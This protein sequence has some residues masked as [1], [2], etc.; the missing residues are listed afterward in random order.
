MAFFNFVVFSQVLNSS[1]LYGFIG[2]IS[3][4]WFLLK[5]RIQMQEESTALSSN[6]YDTCDEVCC[7]V[8]V[9]FKLTCN[10]MGE[11]YLL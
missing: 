7:I 2:G 4:T 3:I 5:S 11:V 8:A 9:V 10:V 6:Y 1:F